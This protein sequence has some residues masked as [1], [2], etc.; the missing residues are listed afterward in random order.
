MM[1]LKDRLQ[2]LGLSSIVAFSCQADM[3]LYEYKASRFETAV[4][5]ERDV[6]RLL[7]KDPLKSNVNYVAIPWATFI[8]TDKLN[9]LSRFELSV[10]GGFTVCQHIRYKEILPILKKMGV[11]V[12]FTPHAEPSQDPAIKV[13]P[14]PHVAVNGIAAKQQKDILYS[15]I[16]FSNHS[17]RKALFDLRWPK[18]AVIKRRAVWHFSKS[19]NQAQKRQLAEKREYQDVLAR[20]RYSLCPRGTGASTLRFWESLQ[21]GAI[22]VLFS[23]DMMLPDFFDWSRCVILI[24]EADIATVDAVIRA[25]SQEKEMAMRKACYEAYAYFQGKNFVSVIRDYFDG[26]RTGSARGIRQSLPTPLS[27]VLNCGV[28]ATTD[29]KG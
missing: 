13:L 10:D 18:D 27:R 19:G 25:M 23:D 28:L 8:N 11:N 26:A 29:K 3:Q 16:G 20:S 5:T 2:V 17:V 24:K 15:F 21:A 9:E 12:L 14:I 6:Y 4:T 7:K 22:P 1:K